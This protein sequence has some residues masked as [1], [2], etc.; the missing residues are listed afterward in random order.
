MSGKRS[1]AQ[2]SKTSRVKRP[3]RAHNGTGESTTNDAVAVDTSTQPLDVPPETL[4][5]LTQTITKAVTEKVLAEIK[6]LLQHQGSISVHNMG[7]ERGN[8]ASTWVSLS[9]NK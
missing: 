1:K 8:N 2:Q 7:G 5:A 9:N 6:P 3:R 4:A